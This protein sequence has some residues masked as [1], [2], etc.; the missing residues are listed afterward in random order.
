MV[1]LK[2]KSASTFRGMEKIFIITVSP[3]MSM[4]SRITGIMLTTFS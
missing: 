4:L 1:D 3:E 2:R